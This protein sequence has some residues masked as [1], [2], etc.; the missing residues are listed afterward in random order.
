MLLRRLKKR[1]TC[2]VTL[3]SQFFA[4]TLG[5][6]AFSKEKNEARLRMKKRYCHMQHIHDQKKDRQWTHRKSCLLAIKSEK[7]I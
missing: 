6:V 7:Q 3:L 4:Q 2:F 1:A 5:G